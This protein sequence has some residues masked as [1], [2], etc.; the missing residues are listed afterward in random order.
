MTKKIN[1]N[2]PAEAVAK[3]FFDQDMAY[4]VWNQNY[5]GP[6]DDTVLGTW[7]RQA[8]AAAEVEDESIRESVYQD[9]IW[10]LTDW[11]GC[12]GGRITSNLGIEERKETTLMN[13]F[14]HH[15]EDI[16]YDDVDS[17]N[18]IYDILKAQANTLKSEGG[19][20][21]NFSWIR[22]NGTYIKGIGSRTPGVIKFMKLWNV[23]SEIITQGSE[24][25]FGKIRKDEKK[26]IRKGAQMG[27]LNV[28]HPEIED[29]IDAKLQQGQLDKFNLSC[30]VT[31]GFMDAVI[32][33]EDWDLKFPDPEHQAYETEWFGDIYDWEEKGYPVIVYNTVKA[34]YLWDKIMASTYK[35]NDP[36]VLFLDIAN[37]LNPLA[38]A[39]KIHASNPCGEILMSTGV[40]NLFSVN[41]TRMF[42]DG[43]F[44]MDMFKRAIEIAVRFSDNI[45]DISNTPLEEYKKSMTEKR[46]IGIGTF[47]LG[48]LMYM[49]GIRYGSQESIELIQQI[50]QTKAETE[51]LAS[52]KLG[53]EKGSF[54][55]FDK[56]KYFNTAW[57]K[58]LKISEDVKKEVEAIGAMR[59]SHRS[60][61]APTGNMGI[62]AGIVSGGIEPVFSKQYSRWSIVVENERASLR[63]KGLEFPDVF[64]GEWFE[65]DILKESKRGEDTILK[66]TFNGINYEVD[67]NRGLVKETFVTDY[68]Y[69]WCQKNLSEEELQ[70]REEAGIFAETSNLSV[71]DHIDTLK[72]IAHYTDMNNSKTVNLPEDYSFDE[73]KHLYMDAYNSG[74]KGITT[75]RAGTMTAVLEAKK[76][77]QEELEETFETDEVIEENVSLPDEF[78]TKGYTIRTDANTK[79]WYINIAFADHEKTKPFALFVNTNAKEGSEVTNETI[80]ELISLAR[81]K[82][83]RDNLVTE[84]ENK[85]T[86][87]SNVVKIARTLGLLL[88]HNI[89]IIDIVDVLDAGNYPLASFTFH[90]KRLLKQFIK[91]GD[92]VSGER[93]ICPECGGQ[94]VYQEGCTLCIG[95][96]YSKCS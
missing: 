57:W 16:K 76:D 44:D 50:Y 42:V 74:I 32:N 55:L 73:F 95:C 63:H 46:R 64:A 34:K 77:E 10:L 7:E 56:D 20:G 9:F 72:I 69:L 19:Y 83:V 67:I 88:R 70:A 25:S 40:C 26:K 53:Q 37:S 80:D 91:N 60:A 86:K 71:K 5:N 27:I 49:A 13:C 14:V 79:K 90:I 6:N 61:N 30:G 41:L 12:G 68:G 75:Y 2:K 92:K 58:Q 81:E 51:I 84:H 39:E 38:Y 48:S 15:P 1:L 59:N 62:Y 85:I 96:G 66:G 8:R 24:K 36:G 87:V 35:R 18:G 65:T 4:E 3:S 11:K 23:S 54:S 28:W 21:T 82:G 33:D 94:I 31:E 78:I 93:G 29:F 89:Q 47:G 17:I 22:P 45:N 43:K 52:A